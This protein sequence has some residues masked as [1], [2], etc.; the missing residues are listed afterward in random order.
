MKKKLSEKENKEL[1]LALKNGDKTVRNIIIEGNISL[2]FYTLSK[3]FKNL[4]VD[5]YVDIGLI[6]LIKSVDSYDVNNGFRFS[7]FSVRCIRNEILM[8]LRKTNKTFNDVSLYDNVANI[9]DSDE[10][11]Y[12]DFIPDSMDFIDQLVNS[13]SYS[14]F[15]NELFNLLTKEE[16]EMLKLF[17][18][19][20][21]RRY[22]QK[23]IAVIYGV[24]KNY[25]CCKIAKICIKLRKVIS[26]KYP[27]IK[28]DFEI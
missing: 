3:Y 25:I 6:G 23:E 5:D 2:V 11:E 28:S 4:S 22:T 9:N 14:D 27:E 17:F 15:I 10:F 18:G 19:F 24:S 13:I 7:T 21:D 12:A 20:Y 16:K 1:F 8:E 26:N